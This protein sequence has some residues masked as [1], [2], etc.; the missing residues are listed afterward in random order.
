MMGQS[1]LHGKRSKLG[2]V[3]FSSKEAVHAVR[4]PIVGKYEML[5]G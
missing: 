3:L 5:K 2:S 4:P 1:Q